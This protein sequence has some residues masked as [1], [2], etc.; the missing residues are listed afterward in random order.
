[1]P[2]S[3]VVNSHALSFALPSPADADGIADGGGPHP[4]EP[5]GRLVAACFN[6]LYK[7][8]RVAFE[9]WATLLR[10]VRAQCVYASPARA[11]VRACAR[12]L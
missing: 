11:S 4:P 9:L 5:R 8:D 10:S 3:F 2:H 7:V 12:V 1:M 6:T